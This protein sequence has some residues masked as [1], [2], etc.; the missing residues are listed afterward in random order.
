M[1]IRLC[2]M[3]VVQLKTDIQRWDY[4]WQRQVLTT[5]FARSIDE[6]EKSLRIKIIFG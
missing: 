1:Q 2:E 5:L 6:E 3:T 4:A